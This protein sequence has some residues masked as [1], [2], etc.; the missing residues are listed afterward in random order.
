MAHTVLGMASPHA[1][2]GGNPLQMEANRQKDMTDRRMNYGELLERAKKERPWL[3]DEVTVEKMQ[4]RYDRAMAGVQA[5]GELLQ[6]TA[7]DVLVVVGDDQYEQ[8]QDDNM[9][10]FCIFRGSTLP[11]RRSPQARERTGSRAWDSSLWDQVRA[12]QQTTE[13]YAPEQPAEPEL[14]EHLVRFMVE[15][16]FDVACSTQ[17]KQD[18]GL[19]HAFTF[20]YS[21]LLPAGGIPMLP[22]MVNT[23]FPPNTPTPR[24]AYAFGQT[25]RR[26]IDA[27]ES[28]R[29]VAVLASGGLSHTVVDEEMDRVLL[30]GIVERNREQL[31]SMPVDRLRKGTSELLNWIVLAGAMEDRDFTSIL[32]YLP[33]YRTEAGTGNGLAIGYWT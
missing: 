23:F 28:N 20:V 21:R 31:C 12:Q 29:R 32:D 33:S 4:A 7:P 2:G 25:L 27:W 30:D 3:V 10:V 8:F 15:E 9:P 17:L 26:G 19:G 11:T 5:L 13:T 14:G 16:G 24:R 18:V 6:Q 22:I 1:F